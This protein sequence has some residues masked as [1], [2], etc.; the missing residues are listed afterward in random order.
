MQNAAPFGA[1][2]SRLYYIPS[3]ESATLVTLPEKSDTIMPPSTTAGFPTIGEPTSYLPAS[4][5][6]A[7]KAYS[8]PSSAPKHILPLRPL[9]A[10][11]FFPSLPAARTLRRQLT[12]LRDLGL[13]ICA[14]YCIISYGGENEQV[15][16]QTIR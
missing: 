13:I 6:S 3:A 5:P 9:E 2:Q 8:L 14:I 4:V 7:F 12:Q 11:L 15:F 10:R 16:A 1:A